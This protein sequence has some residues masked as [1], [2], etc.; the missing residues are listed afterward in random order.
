MSEDEFEKL[1]AKVDSLYRALYGHNDNIG[2]IAKID[3]LEE[4]VS[5]ILK[6]MWF[7]AGIALTYAIGQII[8]LII[9]HN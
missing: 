4:K 3:K 2:L 8:L 9:Q 5:S 1:E 7:V 6:G